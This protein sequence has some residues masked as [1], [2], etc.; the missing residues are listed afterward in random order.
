VDFVIQDGI[1]KFKNRLYVP[2]QSELK[3]EILKEAHNSLFSTHPG[4]TK[5]YQDLKT[6]YWWSGMKKDIADYVAWCLVCQQIKTEHQ[7]PGG[8]LQ[9][10]P[11]PI[12]KWERITM[13]FMV[14]LPR[15]QRHQD[16]IWVIVDRLTKAAHFLA[17]KT[18]FNA[19]QLAELYIKEIVRLHGVPLSIVSDRDTKLASK[20]WQGFQSA[21]GTQLN[22]STAFHPQTDGQ[23]E[24]T[25]QTLEDMLRACAIEY[26]KSWDRNL[27]L[28]E[29]ACNNSYHSSIDM[30][31]YE[32]LYG[33]QCRTPVCWD[34]GERRLSKVELI[35][36]TQEIIDKIREKL[37]TVRSRQKSYADVH[38]RPLAFEVGEHV[39]LKVSPLKGSLRF[40]KK[41]KLS[42]KY[43]GPFEVLQRIGPVAYRL[44]LP[45]TLQGIH[46]VFHVSHLRR[47]I[48]DP[49]HIISYKPLQLKENLTY[50]EEP[51]QILERKDRV[52]RNR[53]ISFVKVLWK[54][55]KTADAT[56]ESELEMWKQYPYLFTPGMSEIS[57][58]KFLLEG[59]KCKD[60]I[61]Y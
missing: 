38:R 25:I 9:P 22:L 16:A 54:H 42:P 49:E 60:P 41:G 48:P 50:V 30:A 39:F 17:I 52:L 1:V 18:T 29:F 26:T 31:P 4:S 11:F 7:K 36:Q 28:V 55:H 8:L 34:E 23:S 12:W 53:V 44:A 5:M 35:D 19:E 6:H 20:F 59:E 58:T 43:I 24:R 40:G 2:N 45:P 27:P 13:D 3:R 33:R 57:R 51:I 56:W 37:Q 46:D 32:A 14:G 47:Y 10:L 21:M 15:T 61:C